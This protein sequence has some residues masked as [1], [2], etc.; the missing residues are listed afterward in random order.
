MLCESCNEKEAT[1]HLTQVIDGDVKKVHLC[2][3]CAA[4]SGFDVN[5]PVSITDI[6][7][8]MGSKT[9]PSPEEPDRSCPRCHMRR[10]DF[11]KTGRLGCPVCYDTFAGELVPLMKAMHRSEQHTGKIPMREGSKVILSAELKR[12]QE[13]LARAIASENYEEAARLRDQIQSFRAKAG[14]EK[15]KEAR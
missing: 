12:L 6:L 4:K 15:K 5:S 10:V 13:S 14:D 3:E 1:I 11:K 2:E 9:A 7:L 8:G